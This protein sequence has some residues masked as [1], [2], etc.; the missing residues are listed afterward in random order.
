MPRCRVSIDIGG[1]FTDL[2]ALNEETG[3]LI[4]VKVA[5]TP[6]E[7]AEGVIEDTVALILRAAL[8]LPPS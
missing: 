6:R 7:P 3:E 4:N 8:K 5:S 1:T 2:V